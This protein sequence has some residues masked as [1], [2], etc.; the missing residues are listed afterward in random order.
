MAKIF[1]AFFAGGDYGKSSSILPPF[2]EAFLSSLNASGH[3]VVTLPH[4][5][6]GAIEWGG[7]GRSLCTKS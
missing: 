5:Y 3:Q 1:M 6:F 4:N 2:Y 7:G